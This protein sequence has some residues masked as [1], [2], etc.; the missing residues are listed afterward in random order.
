VKPDSIAFGEVC[1]NTPTELPVSIGNSRCELNV[2]DITSDLGAMLTISET[3]FT[4]APDAEHPITLT[5]TAETAGEIN[6]TL[7]ITSNDQNSPTV[8]AISAN[9]QEYEVTVEVDK[10][11][12]P[13][14]GK[15]TATITVTVQKDSVPVTDET[16]S[17]DVTAGT[18]GDVTNHNNGSYTAIYTAPTEVGAVTITA[19]TT[20][21]EG[22][23][24]IHIEPSLILIPGRKTAGP[25][26]SVVVQIFASKAQGIAGGDIVVTYNK[27]I[28]DLLRTEPGDFSEMRYTENHN[29]PGEISL[30]I[31]MPEAISEVSGSLVN[32]VFKVREDVSDQETVFAFKEAEVYNKLGETIPTQTQNGTMTIRVRQCVKGDVNYDG[33]INTVDVLLTLQIVVGL[34]SPTSEQSCAAD[35]NSDGK[36]RSNDAILIFNKA[37]GSAAPGLMTQFPTQE[38]PTLTLEDENQLLAKIIAEL[39]KTSLTTEQQY[40]LEQLKQLIGWQSLPGHTTLLQNYPNPFNPETWIPFQLAQ[41]APVTISIY[42]ANGQMIRTISLGNKK[43]GIYI[44]K[45]KA[46]YWDGRDSFGQKAPSGVYFYTIQAGE[47]KATRKMVILK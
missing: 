33:R 28:L 22:A 45:E 14:D 6:G 10:Q 34:I 11:V 47:F 18:V 27:D 13:A 35:I 12:L 17:I 24:T 2:A 42:N 43:A 21:G 5:L 16:V 7:T 29:I 46:A 3:E 44:T 31:A 8:I 26:D 9:V 23:A 30:G 36:V 41:D 32:L 20:C 37:I 15:S 25:K 4:V 38:T 19:T 40:V 39:E 1:V